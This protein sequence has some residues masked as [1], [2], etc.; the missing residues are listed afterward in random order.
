VIGTA[1]RSSRGDRY[2][3][4][5]GE[6]LIIGREIGVG[7]KGCGQYLAERKSA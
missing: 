2:G 6:R 5:C 1:E 4:C 7:S 3:A